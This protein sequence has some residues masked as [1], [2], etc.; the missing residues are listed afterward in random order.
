MDNAQSYISGETDVMPLPRR[1]WMLWFQ[2]AEGMPWLVRRCY[3]SWIECNP[4][5]EVTL[6]SD[7]NLYQYVDLDYSEL[8]YLGK[9]ALSDLIRLELLAKYGGVWADAT[10]LCMCP[11]ENWLPGYFS[12]GF[13]AFDRPGH[14]RPL[15][16]WFI[17][18]SPRNP[19]VLTWC[20]ELR[21]Y[22]ASVRFR[23]REHPLIWAALHVILGRNERTALL[24]FSPFVHRGIRIYPYF[25]IHYKFLEILK[26]NA[27]CS[28]IWAA[29]PRLSAELADLELRRI[30]P[31]RPISDQIIR[32]IN[33]GPAPMYKLTWKGISDHVP[34]NSLLGYLFDTS[35]AVRSCS[36]A[37]A[38]QDAIVKPHLSS[39]AASAGSPRNRR[40]ASRAKEASLER[41]R[42]RIDHLIRIQQRLRALRRA[43]N[44]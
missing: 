22:L 32:E 12:S 38:R 41:L 2:G 26:R 14:D 13:F 27:N 44:D 42:H 21:T 28:A 7:A 11:L 36:P 3:E 10:C 19:L 40:S 24:W 34:V 29:T 9:A 39:H 30:A 1:I 17:A 37:T 25:S 18:A 6:L 8:S 15:A 35:Q 33:Q 16:S 20:S 43:R 5:W 23:N 31:L 4:W